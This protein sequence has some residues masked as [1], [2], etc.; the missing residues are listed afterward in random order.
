MTQ[1]FVQN[2]FRVHRRIL[3]ENTLETHYYLRCSYA[4]ESVA[5]VYIYILYSEKIVKM[6]KIGQ[7]MFTSF[8]FNAI[9]ENFRTLK[10]V[11]LQMI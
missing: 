3:F 5:I 9:L 8:L 6:R 10:C 4:V 11:D 7:L 2:L 1:L